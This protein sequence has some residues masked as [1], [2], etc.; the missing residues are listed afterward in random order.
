M[1]IY[2]ERDYNSYIENGKTLLQT[3]ENYYEEKCFGA[4]IKS[5]YRASLNFEMAKEI[6]IKAVDVALKIQANELE[7]YCLEKID[8]LEQFKKVSIDEYTK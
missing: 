6:A 1:T 8:E 4:A 3:A 7:Y 2:Q 5:Y